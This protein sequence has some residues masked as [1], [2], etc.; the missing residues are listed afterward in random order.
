MS[1]HKLAGDLLG[2]EV[3]SFKDGTT[4]AAEAVSMS[5]GMVGEDMWETLA[6]TRESLFTA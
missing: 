3:V 1:G 2:C 6:E 5:V 4:R